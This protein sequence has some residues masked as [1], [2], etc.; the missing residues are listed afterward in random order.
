LSHSRT[1]WHGFQ[2]RLGAFIVLAGSVCSPQAWSQGS[3]PNADPGL[4]LSGTPSALARLHAALKPRTDRAT[5]IVHYGDSHTQAAALPQQIRTMVA[6]GRP[7]APGFLTHRHPINWDGVVKVTAD[8]TQHNWLRRAS[9][10]PFG[11]MGIAYETNRAGAELSLSLPQDILTQGPIK[12]TALYGRTP[13]HRPFSLVVKERTLRFIDFTSEHKIPTP[14]NAV[15][16]GSST[17]PPPS[18]LGMAEVLLPP[19]ATELRLVTEPAIGRA[20]PLYFFGF[21]IQTDTANVE[22][23]VLGVGSTRPVHLAERGDDTVS[24]YIQHRQPDL[25]MTWFGSN[26]SVDLDLDLSK[27]G[28][29]YRA[30]LSR[31]IAAAPQAACLA[32]G[33]PDLAR[34][35]KYC[36]LTQRQRRLADGGRRGRKRLRKILKRTRK[37]MVCSPNELLNLRKRGRYRFPVPGVKTMDQWKR[38][39]QRCTPKTVLNL[40]PV[41]TIQRQIAHELGCGYFDSFA[42][43]GGEDAILNW[44]CRDE[45]RLAGYDLVHLTTAGYQT[46][47]AAI[48]RALHQTLPMPDAE[49]SQ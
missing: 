22:Y 35:G 43:M 40:R 8:W 27:Y 15:P 36:Y 48:G 26:S 13:G 39:V 34:A 11:P 19:G 23:D 3:D 1:F 44:T 49:R 21:L 42:Y 25:V 41:I 24:A 37:A 29:D 16:K 17:P 32:I 5:V 14:D 18:T 28:Q 20:T 10:P 7:V 38:Y 9:K 47:G 33:P 31:L 2:G 30:H 46:L 4:F 6:A 45:D 12:V